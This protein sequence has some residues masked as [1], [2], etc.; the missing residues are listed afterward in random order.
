V[1]VLELVLVLLV[2][3]LLVQLGQ[4]TGTGA[5]Q[6]LRVGDV[7]RVGVAHQVGGRGVGRV[8]R[9]VPWGLAYLARVVAS[10]NEGRRR[11]RWL[12]A[13]R[14]GKVL[15][16]LRGLQWGRPKLGGGHGGMRVAAGPV[17]QGRA[18]PVG[19]V[20]VMMVSSGVE[21]GLAL[22]MVAP[23]LV[24]R[25]LAGVPVAASMRVLVRMVP[26]ARP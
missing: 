13:R 26:V 14:G 11:W 21:L 12:L 20:R 23:I 8:Q 10:L 22:A 7:A 1:L 18:R 17:R 24:G 15:A 9:M 6:M 5:A 25:R 3:L 19:V 4:Q 16:R 2:L